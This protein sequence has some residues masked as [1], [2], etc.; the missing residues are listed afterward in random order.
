M[1][2]AAATTSFC[3][4]AEHPALPGHFPGAP[5]VPGVLL[6]AEGMQ[7]LELLAPLPWRCRRITS[8]KFLRRVAAGDMITATLSLSD[9]GEGHIEFFVAGALA[10]HVGLITE[11]FDGTAARA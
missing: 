3:I 6:L 11:D 5:V 8:A 4:P 9:D 7:R 10:A 2:F 1:T